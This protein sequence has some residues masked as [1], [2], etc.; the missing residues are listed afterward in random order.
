VARHI[1]G[2]FSIAGV[3]DF[4]W[5]LGDFKIHREAEAPRT[6]FLQRWFFPKIARRVLQY[7]VFEGF[8]VKRVHK[9]EGATRFFW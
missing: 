9:T 8:G 5:T 6:D 3:R 7:E 4:W 1:E 2:T